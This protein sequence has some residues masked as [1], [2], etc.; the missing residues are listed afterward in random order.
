MKLDFLPTGPITFLPDALQHFIRMHILI[1]QSKHFA[2]AL[3]D[4]FTLWL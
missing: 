3:Y 4:E 2:A 1:V